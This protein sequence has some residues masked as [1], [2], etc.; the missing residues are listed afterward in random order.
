MNGAQIRRGERKTLSALWRGWVACSLCRHSCAEVKSCSWRN[1]ITNSKISEQMKK[2]SWS[3][4]KERRA[5]R[6]TC[7]NPAGCSRMK[8]GWVLHSHLIRRQCSHNHCHSD[9]QLV[10]HIVLFVFNR[11][12]FTFNR[13]LQMEDRGL[14]HSHACHS[15]TFTHVHATHAI[16]NALRRG[17]IILIQSGL[18]SVYK[19]ER[20]GKLKISKL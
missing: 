3:D 12:L 5:L 6:W 7:P 15:C 17:G 4:K 2:C 10:Q 18:Q 20:M 16:D 11:L 8:S 13:C 9:S 14:Q 19:V 1:H